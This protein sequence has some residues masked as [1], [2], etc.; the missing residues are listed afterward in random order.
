MKV[1]KIVKRKRMAA[2]QP[3]AEGLNEEKRNERKGRKGEL[4]VEVQHEAV[5]C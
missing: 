2:I 3:T 4:E 1:Y 5:P